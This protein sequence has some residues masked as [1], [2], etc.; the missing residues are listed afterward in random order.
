MNKIGLALAQTRSAEATL[1]DAWLRVGERQS[2]DQE[3]L[4]NG[5]HF[6]GQCLSHIDDLTRFAPKYDA[7]VDSKEDNEFFQRLKGKARHTVSMLIGRRPESGLVLMRD[8]RMLFTL[9]YATS[10]H[11][12]VLGQVAQA[13]RDHDL[14]TMVDHNHKEILT[15]IKWLKTEIK[16]VAPQV[17]CS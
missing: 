1:A 10:F 12:I 17:L 7:S 16:S 8:Q 14:L 11:W 2:V 3:W 13:S 15:Q 5:R 9:G 4:Y 6:R